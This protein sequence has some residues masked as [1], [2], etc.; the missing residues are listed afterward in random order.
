MKPLKLGRYISAPGGGCEIDVPSV[1]NSMEFVKPI[2]SA[3][4]I[5]INRPCHV[6][7]GSKPGEERSLVMEHLSNGWAVG[8]GNEDNGGAAELGI[9]LGVRPMIYQGADIEWGMFIPNRHYHLLLVDDFMDWMIPYTLAM[10]GLDH[11]SKNER[12][13][14]AGVMGKV[15]KYSE[16]AYKQFGEFMNPANHQVAGE[17]EVVMNGTNELRRQRRYTNGMVFC[18]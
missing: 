13:L 18:A 8:L 12:S 14:L 16:Q 3:S 4:G 17:I 7:W 9:T 2:Y 6:I 10:C 11:S 5:P 15:E 1:L